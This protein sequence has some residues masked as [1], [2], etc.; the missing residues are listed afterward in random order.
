V[1]STNIKNQCEKSL[2]IA[3]FALLDLNNVELLDHQSKNKRLNILEFVEIL[4]T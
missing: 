2:E 3:F 1:N 4:S